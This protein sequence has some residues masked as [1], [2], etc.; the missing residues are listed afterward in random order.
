MEDYR[1]EL[2]QSIEAKLMSEVETA[3]AV[4]ENE[5]YYRRKQNG[6]FTRQQAMTESEG[7]IRDLLY[8]KGEGYFWDDTFDGV[9]VILLGRDTEGKLR[10]N[11]TYPTGK[12][13]IREIILNG[14]KSSGGFTDFM[15]PKPNET[16]PLP[17]IG[18]SIAF[19]P[20]QW[21]IGTGVWIYEIDKMIADSQK[22]FDS[23]FNSNLIQMLLVM[24]VLQIFFIIL[25][26]YI[27]KNLVESIQFVTKRLEVMSTGDFRIDQRLALTINKFVECG[28]E[29]GTMSRAQCREY[30]I[31]N[32]RINVAYHK[33]QYS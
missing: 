19:E 2:Q 17:K 8:D 14:R 32:Q 26:I 23:Q 13:F 12:Q 24:L 27:G 6:E 20:Y 5:K 16:E 22:K 33:R 4:A 28:D 21:V 29:L 1:N 30:A 31:Q 9:N 10:I 15:F 25:A 11:A 7:I 3:K 18:Y